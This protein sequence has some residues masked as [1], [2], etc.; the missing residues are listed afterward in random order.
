MT[1][2]EMQRA[3]WESEKAELLMAL[4]LA[5]AKKPS[6]PGLTIMVSKSG[7]GGLSVYGLGKWPV[8]LYAE[9]WGKLLD[10]GDDIRA[11]IKQHNGALAHKAA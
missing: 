7:K 10:K 3:Q 2:L 9:Q 4:K 5:Q 8:T 1:D 6:A 11:F